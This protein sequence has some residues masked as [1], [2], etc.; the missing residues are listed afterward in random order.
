M[1]FSATT[2]LGFVLAGSALAAPGVSPAS[3]VQTADPGASFDVDKI[4]TTPEFV[5]TPDIVLLVD[6]TGSMGGAID[7]IKTNLAN[8]IST[9]KASQ[10]AAEFAVASFGDIEDPNP[11]QVVQGLSADDAVLQTAVNSLTPGGGGDTPEDWI[12]ALHELSTGAVTFRSGSSRVIVLIGDASSHDPSG[13][14]TLAEA[15]ATLQAAN[16]RVIVVDVGGIDS[17]GQATAVTGATGGVIV[18]SAADNVADAIVDGLQ[19]IDVEVTPNIISCDAG[20]TIEFDPVN[21]KVVSGTAATFKETVKVASDATQG[22]TLQCSVSFLLNGAP[23]GDAFIQ[24]IAVTVNTITPPTSVYPTSAYPTTSVYP[25]SV[26]P[27]SVYPHTSAYPTG[28]PKGPCRARRSR[29]RTPPS[30][31]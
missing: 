25:T 22:A 16:I 2:A 28:Y 30:G 29:K 3:V 6:V 13:G 24:S 4:V 12:N 11:F 10:P 7:N 23:G 9:I 15:T 18:D 5:P 21:S 26:Y 27:T 14:R 17:E 20:L 19:R 31:L 8:V 1:R